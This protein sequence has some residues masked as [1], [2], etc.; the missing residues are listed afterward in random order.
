VTVLRECADDGC[1]NVFRAESA[2]RP[3]LYCDECSTGA[4]YNRRWRAGETHSGPPRSPRVKVLPR[5][6]VCKACGETFIQTE[7]RQSYCS[8][9]CR[10]P[11][12]VTVAAVC[13]G[14]G[15]PFEARARDRERGWARFCSRSCAARVRIAATPIPAPSPGSLTRP[16]D[17]ETGRFLVAA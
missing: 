6:Q 3:R 7:P 11:T 10:P 13:E 15:E 16:R 12:G 4:A 14:C 5:D 2:G 1:S 8:D 17:P 9:E